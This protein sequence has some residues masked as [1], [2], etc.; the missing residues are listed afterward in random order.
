MRNDDPAVT[1][2]FRGW[3]PAIDAVTGDVTYMAQFDETVNTY[4]VKFV[5]FDGSLLK[6]VTVAY[7]ETPVYGAVAPTR[8][9]TDK[10]TFVF[11]GWTPAIKAATA[12]AT[13]TATYTETAKEKL[14]CWQRLINF[15][16][17]LI[18][19]FKTIC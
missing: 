16:K 4:T 18:N 7:G 1:Y 17:M 14:T 3:T 6:T 5:N 19:M 13:Y 10:S 9:E 2:T 8:P 15:F 11:A 12:D